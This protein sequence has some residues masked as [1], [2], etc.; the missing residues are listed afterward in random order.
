M[1]PSVTAFPSSHVGD[2]RLHGLLSAQTF[3]G[4]V[5]HA[6]LPEN[7]H[8]P[9]FVLPIGPSARLMA[10]M[11]IRRPVES[12]LDLGCGCGILGILVSDHTHSV[13]ATDINP[14][15]LELT[16]INAQLNGVTN[17]ETLSGSYFEPVRGRK[18][19][20]I[21]A[22]T[23]YVITPHS[24]YLYRDMVS[25]R[26]TDSIDLLKQIPGFLQPNGFA[27]IN[28]CWTHSTNQNPWEP[29][30][31]AI[32]WIGMDGMLF[33]ARDFTPEEYAEFWLVG[34][35]RNSVA[36]NGQILTW[37][38]WYRSQGMERITLGHL[39]MRARP[40]IKN[41]FVI[42]RLDCEISQDSGDQVA[43]LFRAQDRLDR[44]R[45]PGDILHAAFLSRRLRVQPLEGLAVITESSAFNFTIQVHQAAAEA[46]RLFDGQISAQ[47][48]F[49][50][51]GD[52][53]TPTSKA[54]LHDLQL[55]MQFG[56]IEMKEKN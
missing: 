19:D 26:R 16:R 28:L 25:S 15:A 29:V 38:D 40:S 6:D 37:A 32:R 36:F 3:Q 17:V 43:L 8:A 13:T 5:F 2:A 24:K 41:W 23:P 46:I 49:K 51:T 53:H 54:Y 10:H 44:L 12:A 27:H 33:L 22:N 55:L 7:R 34:N 1:N 45:N 47:D 14:R 48:A 35:H 39:V 42:F 50:K 9:D 52:H 11:I 56:M 30:Q 4:K 18:F 20:L 21:L 31:K